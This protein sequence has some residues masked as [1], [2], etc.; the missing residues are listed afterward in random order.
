VSRRLV[1]KTARPPTI[2]ITIAISA[3]VEDFRPVSGN[4]LIDKVELLV[5][6]A[7]VVVTGTVV[8]VVT[9]TVV[10]VVAAWIVTT[11]DP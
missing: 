9:G 8:V 3:F 1:A 4:T 2:T 5:D 11:V 10:V 7:V 6:S